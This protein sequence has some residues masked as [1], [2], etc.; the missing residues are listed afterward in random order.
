MG[1]KANKFSGAH[2][3]AVCMALGAGFFLASGLYTK[4]W[5]MIGASMVNALMSIGSFIDAKS[6]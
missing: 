6:N 2:F 4:Q 5:W 3:F 1:K